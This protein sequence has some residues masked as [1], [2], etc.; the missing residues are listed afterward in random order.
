MDCAEGGQEL[1]RG[2]W[3]M[4]YRLIL[5]IEEPAVGVYDQ[6]GIRGCDPVQ[7]G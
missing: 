7:P 3:D 4:L 5:L 6:K 1:E 2:G